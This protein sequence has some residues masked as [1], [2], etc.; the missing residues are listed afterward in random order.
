MTI[1]QNLK[2]NNKINNKRFIIMFQKW[3]KFDIQLAHFFRCAFLPTII[4]RYV[5]YLI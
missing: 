1:Y 4:T 2:D 3:Q 5:D